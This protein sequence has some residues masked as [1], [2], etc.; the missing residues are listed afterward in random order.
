MVDE[1]F[2]RLSEA[3]G[4]AAS[5]QA[6]IDLI[7]GRAL[8]ME[9]FCAYMVDWLALVIWKQ[10]DNLEDMRGRVFSEV[11]RDVTNAIDVYLTNG[12]DLVKAKDEPYRLGAELAFANIH[13][14]LMVNPPRVVLRHED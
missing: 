5:L 12:S 4:R 8:A 10:G 7:Q 2:D 14:A 3:S 6:E 13:H 11:R 9:A 1:L